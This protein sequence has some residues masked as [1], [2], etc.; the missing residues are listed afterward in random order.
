MFT[1]LIVWKLHFGKFFVVVIEKTAVLK[2]FVT[3]QS[4]WYC[5]TQQWF[6]PTLDL[7]QYY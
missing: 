6:L 4:V 2:I 7:S 5:S 3:E 1:I